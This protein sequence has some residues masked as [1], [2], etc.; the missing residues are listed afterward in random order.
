[1]FEKKLWQK[2]ARFGIL[3]IAIPEKY[4]PGPCRVELIGAYG[5][6]EP[7]SGSDA[8]SL[9]TRAQKQDKGYVRNGTKTMISLRCVPTP[10]RTLPLNIFAL[11][12]SLLS[13]LRAVQPRKLQFRISGEVDNKWWWWCQVHAF[14][15]RWA[16]KII[17]HFTTIKKAKHVD[18]NNYSMILKT[19]DEF[20]ESSDL[21]QNQF[22][23]WMGQHFQSNFTDSITLTTI[24]AK[25]EPSG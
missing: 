15:A 8:F 23:M 25:S 21:T 7:D 19:Y 1:L 24:L 14:L 13:T 11:S 4:L 9:R 16:N 18:L 5:M 6:T 2:C 17:T 3:G 22:L 12:G 10:Q 20:L